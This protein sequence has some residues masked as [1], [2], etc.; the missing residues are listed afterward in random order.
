[1]KANSK[2]VE[3][4]SGTSRKIRL[5]HAPLRKFG[6]KIRLILAPQPKF[7]PPAA[8]AYMSAMLQQCGRAGGLA[9]AG[10]LFQILQ[11]SCSWTQPPKAADS[12][13]LQDLQPIQALQSGQ[14]LQ[15]CLQHLAQPAAGQLSR[16]R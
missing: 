12:L 1:V 11:P 13:L 7:A 2:L 14:Q 8:R 6:R 16:L 15:S 5:K 4:K 3:N 9:V 10:S